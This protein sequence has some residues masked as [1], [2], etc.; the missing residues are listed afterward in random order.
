MG[1]KS[2]TDDNHSITSGSTT[3]LSVQDTTSNPQSPLTNR[4]S[5]ITPSTSISSSRSSKSSRMSFDQPSS[6]RNKTSLG[7]TPSTRSK[8][9]TFLSS[10]GRRT[11][12]SKASSKSA[13]HSPIMYH[14]SPNSSSTSLSS[15][16][17]SPPT[18]T[19]LKKQ[20]RFSL[21]SVTSRF[22]FGSNTNSVSEEKISNG[23]TQSL[24]TLVEVDEKAL[25]KLCDIIP[26]ADR[27]VLEKYLQKAGGKD[28][29][30][31][32]GLYMRDF[33]NDWLVN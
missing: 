2:N 8:T 20:R 25:N 12:L 33:K 11:S 26:H 24:D 1:G 16:P 15:L 31:A 19:T 9:P 32:V 28:D 14:I 23:S 5:S 6:I 29:L 18:P 22:G 30:L 13:V 3:D 21:Q 10:I 4:E 27:D 17:K 7:H